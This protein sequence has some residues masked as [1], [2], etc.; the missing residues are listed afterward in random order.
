[1]GDQLLP[2]RLE[3]VVVFEGG[4][5]S[6]LDTQAD[7]LAEHCHQHGILFWRTAEPTNSLHGR[8]AR[9]VLKEAQLPMSSPD[10]YQLQRLFVKDRR[11]HVREMLAHQSRGELVICARYIPSTIAYATLGGMTFE[12]VMKMHEGIPEPRIAL[13][14][15]IPA[16]EGVR[17]KEEQAKKLAE[18][19]GEPL[20]DHLELFEQAPTLQKVRLAYQQLVLKLGYFKMVDGLGKKEEVHQRVMEW[21]GHETSLLDVPTDH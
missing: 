2:E 18:E 21:L 9:R 7:L 6:G 8:A 11:E 17:R 19:R 13:Y 10:L 14:L 5:G 16:E 3:R 15:D 1:M 12:E 20:P 4:D